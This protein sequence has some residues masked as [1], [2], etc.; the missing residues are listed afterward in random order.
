MHTNILAG[1][2]ERKRELG[3]FS[4]DGRILVERICVY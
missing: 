2:R 3:D 1:K 4:V